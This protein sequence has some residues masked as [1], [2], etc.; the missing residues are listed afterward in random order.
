M[1]TWLSR[2]EGHPRK[3]ILTMRYGYKWEEQISIREDFKEEVML[4]MGFEE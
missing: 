4:K 1:G 3:E 2:S